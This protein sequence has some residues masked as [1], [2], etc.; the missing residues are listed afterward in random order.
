MI[1][2][3]V[4]FGLTRQEAI[5]YQC[6][7]TEGK[8][9]GY[10]VAKVTGISR[11]NAYGALASLVEKGAAYVSEESAKKYIAVTM[12]EFCENYIR[13]LEE[14]KKWILI[15]SPQ[16]KVEEEGYITVEGF[17]HIQNKIKNLLRGVK[18]R[19]YIS[20]SKE[21]L[22]AMELELELLAKSGKK[23]VVITDQPFFLEDAQ[24]YISDSKK[25]QIGMIAD[26]AYVI[27]GEY[28]KDSM[29]T[30]LYSG[31]K[32]FVEVFKSALANEIKIIRYTKGEV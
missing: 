14:D 19:I 12:E 8:L 7:I 5:I 23:V 6:L 30:C 29:N 21:N 9:T 32:N 11:S 28:G 25:N 3:L 15:N 10:E 27:T 24:I 31:Q 20:C 4:K 26:S 2:H 1:E 17:G 18:E 13:N 22:S 16:L